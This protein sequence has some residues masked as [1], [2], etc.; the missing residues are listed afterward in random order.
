MG[1]GSGEVTVEW[2]R[3]SCME[4]RHKVDDAR[5]NIWVVGIQGSQVDDFIYILF[6]TDQQASH[7]EFIIAQQGFVG[8]QRTERENQNEWT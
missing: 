7:I 6:S 4:G 5:I 2:Y 1:S 3:L 8:D